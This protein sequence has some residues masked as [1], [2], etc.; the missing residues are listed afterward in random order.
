MKSQLGLICEGLKA[1]D[2]PMITKEGFEADDII[3][4]I[5]KQASSGGHNTLILTGD[6]DSF[7]LIDKEGTVKVLIPTKGELLEYDWKRVYD[8]LGVYPNQVIDYKGLR[9]DS[10][11]NIPGIKGIGEKTAQK[12]LSRYNNLEEILADCDNIPEN[13]VRN[14]ICEGRDIAILSKELATIIR[15]VDID[16][17]INHASVTLPKI[18]NVSEFLRKMQ[19]YTFI[20]KIDK[21]LSSFSSGNDSN[22]DF[23]NLSLFETQPT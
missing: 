10:S 11:D 16:F 1:F 6:Q 7:Q 17:D 15:D 22:N 18:E 19:F 12:L 3:G 2:I 20:K 5:S 14:K 4:T 23:S 9:G 21:I 8:K 13:A